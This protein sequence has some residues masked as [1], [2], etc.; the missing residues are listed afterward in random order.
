ML[1]AAALAWRPL[2]RRAAGRAVLG[3]PA[4]AAGVCARASDEQLLAAARQRPDD[5]H[6]F[7][8]LVRRHQDRV[9]RLVLS[10]LGPGAE[11]EAD[12]VAQ[13]VFLRV[14]RRMSSFRGES[15][16]RTWL[17]RVAFNLAVDRRRMA[18]WRLPHVGTD[19]LDTSATRKADDNPFAVA[20]AAER[21]RAVERGLHALPEVLQAVVRLHYWM[22][23]SVDEIGET[24]SLP[25][26]T[27]KSYLHR[28][29]RHLLALLEEQ[30]I[31]GE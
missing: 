31:R 22:D 8:A 12:D 18:R 2:Q 30:G 3:P 19:A 24:L 28:G 6:A 4:D 13:D 11:V 21:A 29:R 14:H 27:V 15:R 7:A 26:G 23:Q 25:P 16:F 1:D 5:P 20:S 17:Y 10:V 9:F